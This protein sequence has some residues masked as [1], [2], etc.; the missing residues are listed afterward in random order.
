MAG[1]VV[2]ALLVL[3][4]AFAAA[5]A[6]AE[7]SIAEIQ[8]ALARDGYDPGP[9]NGVMTGKTRRA[10]LAYER[11]AGLPRD[12][13]ASPALLERLRAAPSTPQ[14]DPV[15]EAQAALQRLGFFAGPV[16]GAMGPRTRDAIVRFQAASRLP[17]DP[18][19]SDRLL[20]DLQQALAV[21]SATPPAEAPAEALGRQ[22]L[23]PGVTPPPIR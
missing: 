5:A 7:A 2:A 19:I 20:A 17:V 9:A 3:M 18:R 21:G 12:G 16:D 22:P 6:A 15:K 8:E 13:M 11:A 23:P 1:R 4:P 14:D 10:I